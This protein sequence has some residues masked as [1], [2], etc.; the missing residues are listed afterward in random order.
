MKHIEI[1]IIQFLLLI[2]FI[3]LFTYFWLPKN[4]I[5]KTT[6]YRNLAFKYINL[7]DDKNYWENAYLNIS[8]SYKY[9]NINNTNTYSESTIGNKNSAHSNAIN[10]RNIATNDNNLVDQFLY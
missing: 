1:N 10:P 3:Y 7:L 5:Y 2:I 6:E 4:N 9:N 8:N